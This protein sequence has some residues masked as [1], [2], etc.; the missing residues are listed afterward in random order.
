MSTSTLLTIEDVDRMIA[1]GEFDGPNAKRVELIRGELREMSPIGQEHVDMVDWLNEW[2]WQ[3]IDR[4]QIQVSIQNPVQIPELDTMP[5]PDVVWRRKRRK[6]G[7]PHVPDVML[8]IEVADSSLTYDTTVKAQIYSEAGVRD[9]WVVD[10]PN[11]KLHV[12][13]DPSESGFQS[14]EVH[15][16]NTLV[17]PLLVPGVTLT[18]DE[19]FEVLDLDDSEDES[20]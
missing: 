15:S 4:S 16:G 20:T 14:R 12:F 7:R 11:R 6:G 17:T 5:H 19:L 1:R 2:S 3:V 13:R 18:P 10:L 9:Y 8:L